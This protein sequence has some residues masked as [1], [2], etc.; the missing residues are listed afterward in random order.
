MSGWFDVLIASHSWS[1]LPPETFLM[2]LELLASKVDWMLYCTQVTA[3]TPS[4]LSAHF[5]APKWC[6]G[7]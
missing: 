7:R 5:A 3:S 6:P 1:E 2:Y 4:P